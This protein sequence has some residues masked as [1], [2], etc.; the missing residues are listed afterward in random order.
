MNPENPVVNG[1]APATTEPLNP[2]TTAPVSNEPPKEDPRSAARFA[3]LAR[4]EK[5]A[6]EREKAIKAR[7]EKI[8]ADEAKF[9][10]I[11]DALANAKSNPTA[12][13]NAAGV[14]LDEVISFT[15]RNGAPAEEDKLTVLERRLEDEKKA[16][17]EAEQRRKTEEEKAQ[18]KYIETM[19]DSYRTELKQH[20]AQH[21]D[22][23]ELILASDAADE[24]FSTIV[25][26][27]AQTGQI[28]SPEVAAKEYEA[29]LFAATEKVLGLKKFSG[30]VKAPEPAPE[31]KK[32]QPFTPPQRNTPAPRTL[33]SSQTMS[34][35]LVKQPAS[36]GREE[37][38]KAAAAKLV[39]TQK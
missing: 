24:V 23:Y 7:E 34:A 9:Q 31:E 36:M 25:E 38:M 1:A 27:F 29:G 8:A 26:H 16:R 14:T 22:D 32:E 12:I 28:L 30:R 5:Q 18:Q 6:V 13:L 10:P 37:R 21:P 4:R 15:L 19:I 2:E 20:L 11:V 33:S 17:E 3:A 39:F 35:P